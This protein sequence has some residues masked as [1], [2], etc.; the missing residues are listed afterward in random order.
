MGK[1]RKLEVVVVN[2]ADEIRRFE[3]WL[4]KEH[5]LEEGQP[6]GDYMRQVAVR[7]G[8]WVALL[9]WGACSYALQDRDEWIGWTRSLRAQRQKLIVQNRRFLVPGKER[10]PNLASQVLTA[11]VKA[12]PAQWVEKFGYSPVLAE[13]FTDIELFKG[14]CYRAAGWLPVGQTKGYGRH[15]ADFYRFHGRPKK[16]WLKPLGK[17]SPHQVRDLLCGPLP[18]VC[19]AGA[20]SSASGMLPI[21][22]TQVYS[23]AAALQRVEDPR[24]SNR[25]FRCGTI[26]CIVAMA[27]LS[28]CRNLSE[29]HRFGQ[30]LKPKHRARLG[31]P[32]NRRYPKL[33]EVPSYQVYYN[34]LSK[35]PLDQFA[36]GLNDWLQAG[37]GRLPAALAMDGKMI[38]DLIG[39][40]SLSE[41]DSGV[42]VAVAIQ[43]EKK[44]DGEHCEL[45]VGKRT[46]AAQLPVLDGALVSSDALHTQKPNAM[47]V[48]DA[49]GDYL[50]QVRDN[51]R[52]LRSLAAAKAAATPLLPSR[53]RRKR[54]ALVSP[55]SSS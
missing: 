8:Q 9:T 13:T 7:E 4:A 32:R 18:S 23:L 31:L 36:Q 46:L 29:I 48:T 24:R 27:L 49:G 51:R 1:K 16:L 55:T 28:G 22:D 6:V 54:P 17:L 3:E 33:F 15:R 38:R 53:R 34:L 21:P 50:F 2:S 52:K 14:T 26:L 44:G 45:E 25:H 41:H 35:L 42:P 10:E 47:T 19:K 12:L 39:V 40:L 20:Q 5:Y 37:R 11:A 30:R 43:T